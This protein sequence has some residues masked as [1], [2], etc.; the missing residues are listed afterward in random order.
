MFEAAVI[1]YYLTTVVQHSLTI[2]DSGAR[3]L[4][5]ERVHPEI[6]PADEMRAYTT[7][8]RDW[9][10][11]DRLP[12]WGAASLPRYGKS[13]QTA[14]LLVTVIALLPGTW[15]ALTSGAP[16]GMDWSV[17][18]ASALLVLL[19][20]RL[21][22]IGCRHWYWVDP[23][24]FEPVRDPFEDAARPFFWWGELFRRPG[25][26]LDADTRLARDT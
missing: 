2:A 20:L 3:R 13:V 9:R 17:G 24:T 1:A 14:A 21:L 25:A 15:F 4:W 18:I 11:S 23:K 19:D 6:V 12:R 22:L 26:R 16:D 8:T 10:G 5:Y 7:G